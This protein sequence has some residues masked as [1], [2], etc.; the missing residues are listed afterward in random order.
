MNSFNWSIWSYAPVVHFDFYCIWSTHS[1][2]KTSIFQKKN[3][4]GVSVVTEF[5]VRTPGRNQDKSDGN[6][7]YSNFGVS[8]KW[9]DLFHFGKW[10]ITMSRIHGD[11]LMTPS[12]FHISDAI[13]WWLFQ[14]LGNFFIPG[15]L[16]WV[17]LWEF[18]SLPFSTNH[19]MSIAFQSTYKQKEYIQY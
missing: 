6:Q 14:D 17:G 13:A 5:A 8:G 9:I 10:K 16:G 3:L 7:A 19:G 15:E 1:S 11:H 4:L 12:P 18:R 2:G